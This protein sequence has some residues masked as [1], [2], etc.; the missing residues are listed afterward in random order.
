MLQ[1]HEIKMSR[2]AI[3]FQHMV[4]FAAKEKT[5][6][7]IKRLQ[8]AI[9]WSHAQ[10]LETKD[11]V[12]SERKLLADQ[13]VE[14]EILFNSILK[15]VQKA[16]ADLTNVLLKRSLQPAKRIKTKEDETASYLH[17]ANYYPQ[18]HGSQDTRKRSRSNS[19]FWNL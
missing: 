11:E 5:D 14:Q 15:N 18:L 16:D 7:E 6:E 3:G 13:A 8:D 9:L 1:G 2:F 12:A 4:N 19:K 17:H 10:V